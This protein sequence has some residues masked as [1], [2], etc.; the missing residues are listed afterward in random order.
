MPDN[1]LFYKHSGRFEAGG[2]AWSFAAMVA[3][4][5]VLGFVYGALAWLVPSV[6]LVIFGCAGLGAGVGLLCAQLTIAAKTRNKELIILGPTL[7]SFAALY[8]AWSGYFFAASDWV[9]LILN[10][11]EI[12]EIAQLNAKNG[13]WSVFGTTPKGI[14]LWLIWLA[15]AGI[16]LG[17]AT[18]LGAD[19]PAHLPFNENADAWADQTET[20]PPAKAMSNHTIKQIRQQLAAGDV[21][22][23]GLF[24]PL[25][26][27][28]AA[29][30]TSF[31]VNWAAGH[32][33][34]Q[35]LSITSI[36]ITQDE[37][38][39]V[40]TKKD[41]IAVNMIIDP[42]ARAVIDDIL[43]SGPQLGEGMGD[44]EEYEDS[45][46]DEGDGGEG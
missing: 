16:I 25:D 31:R 27:E 41:P 20:L 24:E 35:F 46:T 12:F 4:G 38:G 1:E 22:C 40:S 29:M 44:T 19:K 28:D 15:E 30:H 37:Q 39:N 7:A 14:M 8:A 18:F 45:P 13:M 43:A 26:Y 32:E 42:E 21:S 6:Y 9:S 34:E 5:V 23:F 33:A 17:L 3:V 2:I 36:T 11:I 10:P